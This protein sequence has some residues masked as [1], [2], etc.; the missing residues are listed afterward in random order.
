VE[1]TSIGRSAASSNARPSSVKVAAKERV[2]LEKDPRWQVARRLVASKGFA[3]SRFLTS[4]ILY[5]CE[6][7]LLDQ[8][9][10]INE[11][12]I[13]EH[14][15]ERRQGYNPGDDNIVRNYARLL[16][17]RLD[18][19]FTGDGI[20][21]KI[22]I[23]VPR[24]GY[25]P[26]FVE[27]GTMVGESKPG[28][29]AVEPQP[30]GPYLQ[31]DKEPFPASSNAPVTVAQSSWALKALC[32]VLFLTLL[33]VLVRD[34]HLVKPPQTA[35]NRFWS[36]FFSPTRDTLVVPADSGLAIYQ[37]FSGKHT[38]LADY[39]AGEYHKDISAPTGI[40]P[41]IVNELGSR[42]YTSVVDLNLVLSISQL[43]SVVRNR[44]KVRY[45]REVTLDDLKQ[46]NVILLGSLDSNPWAELFQKDLNFQ[47][48]WPQKANNVVI[49]N[50]HPL[51]GEKAYYE[52]N[53]TDPSRSTFGVIAVTPNLD[54]TG[55]V[56]LVEGINMAG[57][58]A[59]A[60]Y[61]FSDASATLLKQVFDSKGNVLPFEVL[62]ETSNIGANAPRPVIISQR[63]ARR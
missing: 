46:S 11:Q 45:A 28:Y 20:D 41:E 52:T 62:L 17:Q 21:E 6:K 30:H 16:R 61:L 1:K 35:T 40:S 7:H 54:G 32:A 9:D 22:R 55:H 5:I 39:V 59:A 4:F 36:V 53:Q 49:H 19:Y 38:H 37:D 29:S 57:T 31:E 47:F 15:F 27:E 51:P 42:R 24:G 58:E 2:S 13:G 34:A 12:Q 3:K 23:V 26:L 10:E 56:L 48:E 18:E 50:L 44:F 25:V 43:P 63:I 60:D 33:F 8:G 14:V